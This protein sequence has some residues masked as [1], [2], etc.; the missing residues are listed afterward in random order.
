MQTLFNRVPTSLFVVWII[1]GF[2]AMFGA[3][4]GCSSDRPIQPPELAQPIGQVDQ[5]VAQIDVQAKFAK[6][7]ANRV[8]GDANKMLKTLMVNNADGISANVEQAKTRIQ[9]VIAANQAIMGQFEKQNEKIKELQVNYI[10]QEKEIDKLNHQFF[11]PTQVRWFWGI[12]L[13]WTA[14]TIIAGIILRLSPWATVQM[15]GKFFIRI[16]PAMNLASHIRDWG[17]PKVAK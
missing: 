4:P 9:A 16:L 12:L 5:S 14:F 10:K 1:V 8:V 3:I 11:S 17:N 13:G 2:A 15:I 7:L 6:D